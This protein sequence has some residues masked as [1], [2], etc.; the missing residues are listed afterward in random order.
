MSP[1]TTAGAIIGTIQ[2]ISPEQIECKEADA[3]SDLFALGAVPYEMTTGRRFFEG[4]SQSSVAAQ[5]WKRSG[6]TLPSLT[7]YARRLET[8]K[9]KQN[10]AANL[11]SKQAS[12]PQLR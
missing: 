9:K 4:K 6:T 7:G 10:A 2:Y 5:F 3:R 8:E 12:R 11:P 1:L